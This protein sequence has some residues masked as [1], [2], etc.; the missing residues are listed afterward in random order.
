[1]AESTELMGPGWFM[2]FQFDTGG[3]GPAAPAAPARR[4]PNQIKRSDYLV[5]QKLEAE[6]SDV[7]DIIVLLIMSGIIE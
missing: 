2:F 3:G 1:M 5:A 7:N 6:E 4:N